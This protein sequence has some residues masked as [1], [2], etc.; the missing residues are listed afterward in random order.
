M[1]RPIGAILMLNAQANH[2]AIMSSMYTMLLLSEPNSGF[3]MLT[4]LSMVYISVLPLP[5]RRP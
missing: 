2:G 3:E 5:L 1:I 4:V